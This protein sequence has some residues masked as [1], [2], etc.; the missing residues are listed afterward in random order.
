MAT[1]NISVVRPGQTRQRISRNP[2]FPVAGICKPFGLYPVFVHPVLPGETMEYFK[3]KI[4]MISKPVKHPLA[5]AWL[6]SWLVYVKF[7]DLD[8]SLGDMFISDTYSTVGHTAAA[9]NDRMFVRTG[10]IDWVKKCVDRIAQ[11]YFTH[12]NEALRMI[13]GVPQTKLNIASWY[14]NCIFEEA[15]VALG[16]NVA[17]VE[18]QITAYE[19]MRQMQMSEITYEKYLQQYGVQSIQTGIGEPEILR[20][21]RS[22][23]Q[24]VN[25]VEPTTGAPS[26][27]WVWSDEIVSEKPKR[28]QEPGF[29]IMLQAVRPKMYAKNIQSSMVG[30]LWGF[31]D[32]FPAYNLEEPS[33]GAKKIVGADA[34][35]TGQTASVI[36]DHRDLLVHGEQF[37]NSPTQPFALPYATVPEMLVATAN[38]ENLRGEYC[39]LGDVDGLFVSAIAGDKFCYYEGIAS[40]RINGHIVDFTP[41][42]SSS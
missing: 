11:A 23:T 9:N 1:S 35:V 14:Q 3:S 27:A 38:E 16:A 30:T 6:E 4:R 26:S 33:A 13:D 17:T 31:S 21:A 2:N 10:Q 7:T 19:M 42:G 41:G 24:P 37:I 39:S 20:Y 34:V 12:K 36:Y 29:I 15:A 32:W 22:W 40:L 18:G 28:F 25:T 8:R 5:G